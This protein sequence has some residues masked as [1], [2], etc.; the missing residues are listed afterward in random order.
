VIAQLDQG[1]RLPYMPTYHELANFG[2]FEPQ[3]QPSTL[4]GSIA[5]NFNKV[6]E[7]GTLFD[8]PENSQA[9]N[10]PWPKIPRISKD[11][12]NLSSRAN[13]MK[14]LSDKF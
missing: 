4:H 5:G 2:Q 13:Y 8:S 9:D 3:N 14:L 10:M 7:I 11:P 1:N 6:C 12:H